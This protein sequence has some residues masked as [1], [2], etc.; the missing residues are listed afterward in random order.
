MW[1]PFLVLR[2]SVWYRVLN[3]RLNNNAIVRVALKLFVFEALISMYTFDI[4]I[5]NSKNL[6][7]F[8]NTTTT[9]YDW[10]F[11]LIKFHI[12]HKT[13]KNVCRMG[14][15]FLILYEESDLIP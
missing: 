3:I 13:V 12:D 9:N 10:Y 11:T 5:Y 4:S 2:H 15:F 6:L 14:T 7:K 8:L 1:K